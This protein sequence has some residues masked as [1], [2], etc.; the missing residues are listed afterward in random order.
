[1]SKSTFIPTI[2]ESASIWKNWTGLG[3]AVFD[4]HALRVT[5]HQFDRPELAMVG[6]QDGR[7]LV[8]QFGDAQLAE[9]TLIAGEGHAIFQHSGIAIDTGQR[10]QADPLPGRIRLTVDLTLHFIGAPAQS[11]EGNPFSVQLRKFLVGGQF[12]VE[13]QFGGWL[14][15][16]LLP[17]PYE[18]ENLIG[19]LA[20]GHTGVGI[21]QNS[22]FG[23]ARQ[24]NQ[25]PL[26]GAAAAGNI[27]LF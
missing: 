11:D 23:I 9:F 7:F 4:E 27:V 12:R 2:L 10:R 17:E 15:G 25:N 19:L 8:P 6:Q 5:G 3:D 18:L 20:F 22:L 13:N 26:L 1:M 24:E 21:A 16:V 14:A